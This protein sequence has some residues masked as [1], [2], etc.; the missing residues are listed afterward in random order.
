MRNISATAALF[1]LIGLPQAF[2]AFPVSAERAPQT[3]GQDARVRHVGYNASD[4]IRIDLNLLTNTAVE[5]GSG[6]RIEQVLLG[7]SESFEVEVLSNRDTISIKPVVAGA[8]T[9]MTIYT[10]RRAISF[11][12]AEG[13]AKTPTYRVAVE[14]PDNRPSPQPTATKSVSVN[15]D[16]N[17]RAS[18]KGDIRPV[19]VWNNGTATYFEFANGVRP[20][21]FGLNDSGME[22]TLNSQTRSNVVRVSGVRN[23]Y[24]VRLGKEYVCI[25]RVRGDTVPSPAEADALIQ[26]EF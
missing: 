14:F 12:L 20:S 2:V 25:T 21:V 9:N 6:E 4:V 17:Y 1:A 7:D 24:A 5:L 8:A 23:Q 18:G 3:L 11:V 19:R 10:G 15:R 16:L 13:R 22:T 26:K